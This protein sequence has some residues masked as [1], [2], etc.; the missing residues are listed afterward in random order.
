MTALIRTLRSLARSPGYSAA[1]IVTLALGIG[2]STAM[3]GVIETA[4]FRPL[5]YDSPGELYRFRDRHVPSDGSGAVSTANYLD[6][7]R[8]ARGFASIAA[9]ASSSFN[10]IAGDR[11]DRA[12]GLMVTR[13]FLATL[14][15]R[16]AM[17]RDFGVGEDR[18]GRTPVAVISH[19][20]WQDRFG[21]SPEA[22]GGVIHLNAR[23]YE[24]VGV[25]PSDF[26]FPGD[27]QVLVPFEWTAD[28]E[29]QRGNR[30]LEGVARLDAGVGAEAAED[31]IRTLYAAL[32]ESFP[33]TN[34]DWTVELTPFAEWALG[35]NRSALF[36]LTGAVG[37]VLIIGAVNV[38]NLMLVRSERRSVDAA[39]RAALGAGRGRIARQYI[40]EGVLIGALGA[41]VGLAVASAATMLLLRWFG[42]ELPRVDGF[43]L[44]WPVLLFAGTL[45]VVIGALVGVVTAARTDR[46]DLYG[47]LRRGGR[48]QAHGGNRLQSSLVAAQ[49]AI[50]VVVCSGAA[51][52]LHS[53]QRLNAVDTGLVLDNAVVFNVQLPPAAYPGVEET[54]SFFRRA[55]E[56]IEAIPGVASVGVSDRTP[57]QG[58]LNMT[59]VASPADPERIASFVEVRQVTPRFFEAAGI[60]LLEGRGIEDADVDQ[61]R[62]VIVISDVLANTLFPGESAVGR[63]LFD[64]WVDGGFR[65][66]GV[67]GSVRDF[68]VANP[69]R[70]AIY[71]PL[72]T[73][74][75]ASYGMVFT[76]RTGIEPTTLFP[77]LRHAIHEIDP[78]LPIF[79]E[80]TLRDVMVQTTGARWMATNLFSAFATLSLA[81]AGL[82]IFGVLAYLVEQRRREIGIRM[83]LGATAGRVQSMVIGRGL[84]LVMIGLLAG[85]AGATL[86]AGFV[87]ELLFEVPSTDVRSMAVVAAV[88]LVAAAAAAALPAWRATRVEPLEAI[89]QE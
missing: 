28:D 12:A 11:P 9:F 81:L 68:G 2:I 3:F 88:T 39:V 22:L 14:G 33:A 36:I 82:G 10:L 47:M 77:A 85:L 17:G 84:K 53:F 57:L 65:I 70:P 5:P 71:W 55:V 75:G 69:S 21:A 61:Q 74:L 73:A 83:A 79:A 49:V 63:A 4:L 29:E 86:L 52:L 37:L 26:W 44:S 50:A 19:R 6:L 43:A 62:D 16:P 13:T 42:G 41:M 35:R 40:G 58:G 32:A 34:R 7:E 56:R 38:A 72:G 60:P 89:R 54:S 15:V 23:Q 46:R 80:R 87:E 1:A 76:V 20:L 51:L 59:T 45:A 64:G 30:W 25:L 27:P 48:G 8:S 66:V 31:E 78:A 24:I 67:V 18:V